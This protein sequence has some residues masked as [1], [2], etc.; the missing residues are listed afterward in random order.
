MGPSLHGSVLLVDDA[1]AI[2]GALY[3]ALRT[4]PG[5]Q[6]RIKTCDSGT[7]ALDERMA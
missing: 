2:T 6:V 1:P 3:A 5:K 4:P 7:E